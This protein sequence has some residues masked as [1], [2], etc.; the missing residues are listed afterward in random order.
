[1]LCQVFLP[2]VIEQNLHRDQEVH[3]NFLLSVLIAKAF[4]IHCRHDTVRIYHALLP[5]VY[6]HR[7]FKY[8]PDQAEYL[9]E[10]ADIKRVNG[11]QLRRTR[12]YHFRSPKELSLLFQ[13]LTCLILYLCSG[14]AQTGYLF[15]Y[16]ENPL[17]TLVPFTCGYL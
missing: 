2:E 4:V 13:E 15:D 5:N 11:V 16:P 8:G 9:D 10:H 14:K 7:I 3:A 12:A 1:M 17:H 6:L